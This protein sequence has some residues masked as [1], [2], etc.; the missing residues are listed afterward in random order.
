MPDEKPDDE[1]AN[2]EPTPSL[3][4]MVD[5]A[6]DEG[7]VE[8]DFDQLLNA[9]KHERDEY[10][11]VARRL[12]ADFENYKKRS[13]KQMQDYAERAS[14]SLL[15]KLLDVLDTIDLALHHEPSGPLE[16]VAVALNEVLQREGLERIDSAG[17]PF[18]PEVH[19]AVA[20]EDSDDAPEVVEV[21][22]AGYRYKGKVIRP[23][24]VKVKGNA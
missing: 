21:M 18:D 2:D 23:A 9:I 7:K 17:V 5:D 11:D 4:E 14:E 15:T 1:S 16:H 3:E 19:D 10:L 13:S 12:Q 22:R 24:M 8:S 20:H 6:V